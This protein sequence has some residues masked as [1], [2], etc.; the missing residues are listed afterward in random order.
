MLKKVARRHWSASAL[1]TAGVVL[2]HGPSSKVNTTSWSRRKSMVLKCCE[3]KPGPPVV[4]IST[5]RETPMA[6]GLAQAMVGGLMAGGGGAAAGA[7]GA[8]AATGAAAGA[9]AGA[10]GGDPAGRMVGVTGAGAN[11]ATTIGA[12]TGTAGAAGAATGTMD[13]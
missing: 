4:S 5:T 10:A 6:L 9:A 8:G 12:A 7:A 13:G 3:P 11:C 1:S 2:S